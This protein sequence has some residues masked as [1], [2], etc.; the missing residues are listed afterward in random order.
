MFVS[1]ESFQMLRTGAGS[2]GDI[3]AAFLQLSALG[4]RQAVRHRILVPAFGGSNPPA[5]AR[6]TICHRSRGDKGLVAVIKYK[7]NEKSHA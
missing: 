5:P 2:S 4:R 7:L 1:K 3:L 6:K